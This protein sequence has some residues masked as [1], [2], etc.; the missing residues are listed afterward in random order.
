MKK[1]M[2]MSFLVLGIVGS[3]FLVIAVIEDGKDKEIYGECL[4]KISDEYCM[5]LDYTSSGVWGNGLN[6][7]IYFKCKD[8]R[9]YEGSGEN[10]IWT[11]EEI[12]FCE[13][14]LRITKQRGKTE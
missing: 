11:S 7:N 2:I 6:R 1:L 9:S 8:S 13:D 3:Y 4:K 5:G 12:D 10:L 14:Q